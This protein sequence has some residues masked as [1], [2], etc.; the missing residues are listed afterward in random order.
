MNPKWLHYNNSLPA[1]PSERTGMRSGYHS[2]KRLCLIN[3]VVSRVDATLKS[4]PKGTRVSVHL[5]DP[6]ADYFFGVGFP[7]FR[8]P[9]AKRYYR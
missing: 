5:K 3:A 6:E 1:R 7:H 4:N 9:G 8:S 2:H